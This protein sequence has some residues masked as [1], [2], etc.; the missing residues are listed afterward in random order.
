[1]EIHSKSP[2]NQGVLEY[3]GRGEKSGR[4]VIAP[5]DSVRDP[6]MGQGSHPDVVE[7]VWDEIGANL[8]G[9]RRCLIYGTPSLIQDRTG[10]VLAICNGTQYNLRLTES[11]L[12]AALAEGART[13]TKW[14]TGEEMDSRVVLG[15]DWIF[16]GYFKEEP[17]WCQNL[18]EEL[19]VL[20]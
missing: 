17:R 9:V 4:V 18:S 19:S 12:R 7:R 16:G 5:P 3:L 13:R 2:L 11:D 20:P 8:P 15:P 14:S 6:Y 10:I 1:M